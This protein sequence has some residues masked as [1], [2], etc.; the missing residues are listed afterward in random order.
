MHQYLESGLLLFVLLNPFLMS[1]YLLEFITTL[2]ARQF[3][4]VLARGALIS[5]VVFGIF[6]WGGDTIFRD[7]L[8]VRFEAFQIFG[9]LIF[10]VIGIKFVFEGSAAMVK[11]RGEP[12]QLAGTIAMPF[13]IGPGTVSAA[14]VIGNRL[15]LVSAWVVIGVSLA[16]TVI[17]LVALKYLHDHVKTRNARLTDRYIDIVGRVSALLIGT[18]AL[19]MI[20]SGL[21]GALKPL[22]N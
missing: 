8:Q 11:L 7:V 6:A 18:F 21:S 2:S 1:I 10:L 4:G 14:V 16:T 15:P 13:M 5:G 19:D 17:M 9:G 3:A 22:L 20:L 12:E